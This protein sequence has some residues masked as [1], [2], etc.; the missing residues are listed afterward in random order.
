MRN[1]GFQEL[2]AE[3]VVVFVSLHQFDIFEEGFFISLAYLEA[4]NCV[5]LVS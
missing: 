1:L 5:A 4:A 3:I 2:V